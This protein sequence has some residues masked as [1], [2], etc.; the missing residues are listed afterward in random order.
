V[1]EMA[2]SGGEITELWSNNEGFEWSGKDPSLKEDINF[3]TLTVTPEYG[4]TVG[5]QFIA[6]RD[7]SRA[8]GT[9]SSAI[10]INKTAAKVMGLNNPV[11][12]GVQWKIE[13]SNVDKTF[14]IIGVIQD[15]VMRSPYEPIKPTIFMLEG[16]VG[17]INIRIN[18]VVSAARALPKIQA[19][20]RKI[21]P[22]APFDFKF[23]SDEYAL[24]FATEKRMST[25]AGS[26][27]LIAIFISCL[28]LFGMAVFVAEQRT[29]EIGVRKILGATVM[30]LWGL[31]S[32]EFILLVA[33]SFVVAAPVAYLFMQNWL[34]NYAYRTSIPWW[35]FAIAG[36]GALLLALVTVSLQVLKAAIANP[37]ISLR[38]E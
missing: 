27:A 19:V 3:G 10:I 37:V 26:S 9:D 34:Q 24:K 14:K 15:M 11:G 18:P 28:G 23:A 36:T 21:V 35:I 7:F 25:L 16:H 12:Q 32:K 2:G 13:N 20:F 30:N 38:A 4:K 8:Y 6:G 22:S 33:I 17:W 5:W 29:K 1:A 31:L